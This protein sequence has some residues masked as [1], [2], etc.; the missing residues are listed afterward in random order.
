MKYSLN[1]VVIKFLRGI[2]FSI[3][4]ELAVTLFFVTLKFLVIFKITPATGIQA[5]T[6]AI[7]P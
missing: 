6:S 1:S 2:E 7:I 4:L 3:F 5:A